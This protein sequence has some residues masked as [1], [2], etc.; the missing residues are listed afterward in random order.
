MLQN[1][2]NL[3]FILGVR[4]QLLRLSIMLLFWVLWGVYQSLRD[5]GATHLE[6]H[7]GSMAEAKINWE[8][9]KKKIQLKI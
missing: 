7:L 1:Q 6:T 5:L 9:T 8:S 2:N 4:G 3:R